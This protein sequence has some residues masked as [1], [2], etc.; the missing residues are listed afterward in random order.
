MNIIMVC[1]EP[2]INHVKITTN[3]GTQLVK[4]QVRGKHEQTFLNANYLN[5]IIPFTLPQQ[6]AA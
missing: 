3:G 4:S 6:L 2:S 5:Q 1:T